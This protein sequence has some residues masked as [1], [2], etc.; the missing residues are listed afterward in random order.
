MVERFWIK[1]SPRTWLGVGERIIDEARWWFRKFDR[2]AIVTG[3]RSAKVSGALDDVEKILEECGTKY[4]VVGGVVPNPYAELVDRIAGDVWRFGAEALVA[5][6]GG[7]V[8]D[9]AKLC[10]AIVARGG[11]AEDYMKRRRVVEET[12][13]ILAVNL[14]HGTGSEVDKY[15][16][17]TVGNEKLSIASE[18]LY[19]EVAIDDP[20]YVATLPRNQTIYTSIDAL[21]HA[22]EAATS[23]QASPFTEMLAETIVKLVATYL[24]RAVENPKDLE[25][26]YWLLY[27]SSLAG[28]AIDHGRVHI[29]HAVEHGLSGVKPELPHGAGLG[30]V[31]P[32]FVPYM[33]RAKPST[34]ARILRVLDPELEPREEHGE[35]AMRA[36]I[37]FLKSVGFDERLSNYGFTSSDLDEA[38][39]IVS[40]SLGYLARLAPFEVD[41]EEVRK[42]LQSVL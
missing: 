1:A 23:I 4:V 36:L 14:T 3:R 15:A 16:V 39:R 41:I 22:I 42:M 38:C 6:G 35:R 9:V 29:V 26:R 10:S 25:A 19:P 32:L 37:N 7:S 21:F 12:I 33:Y 11:R 28:I 2:V 31:G 8:I 24:P 13:P 5:I 27:A 30:I 18:A 17:I 40:T 34:M 20:R